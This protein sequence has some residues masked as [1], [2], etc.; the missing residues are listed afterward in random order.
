MPNLFEGQRVRLAPLANS[1]AAVMTQ[2][3]LDGDYLRLLDMT[4][5]F[6]RNESQVMRWIQNEQQEKDSFLF[7]IRTISGDTLIGFIEI[8]GILWNHGTGWLAVGIGE[9]SYRGHGYGFEALQLALKFVFHEL[10]LYRLQLTVF[11]YNHPAI[12]LYEKLGFQR[13]G[14]YRECLSRDGQRHDMYLYG[15][16]YREWVS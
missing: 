12:A 3:Q 16:L 15:L 6:P 2:W 1:D 14:V 11:S 4:A 10:N 9:S 13:E 8:N 5:A 7:G